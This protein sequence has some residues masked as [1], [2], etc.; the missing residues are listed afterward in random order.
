MI[1]WKS[2]QSTN[3]SQLDSTL[4]SYFVANRSNPV[5]QGEDDVSKGQGWPAAASH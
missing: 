3:V 4:H 2:V 1:E 5:G